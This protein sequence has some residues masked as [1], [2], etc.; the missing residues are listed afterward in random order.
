MEEKRGTDKLEEKQTRC[1]G[2]QPEK[3][4]E[5]KPGESPGEYHYRCP[6]CGADPVVIKIIGG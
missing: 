4:T 1:C 6:K 5:N 2:V 3:S